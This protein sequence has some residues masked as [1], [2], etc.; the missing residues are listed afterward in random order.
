MKKTLLTVILATS[1]LMLM[2]SV[3]QVCAQ[4]TA[5]AVAPAAA[6]AAKKIAVVDTQR[7]MKESLAAQDAKRQLEA[8]TD[9]YRKDVAKQ[10]EEL[11][12]KEKELGT[13]K[14]VLSADAFE[15]KRKEFK[16]QYIAAQHKVQD[17][18]EKLDKSLA[19]AN[20]KIQNAVKDI[21]NN[22]AKQQGIDLVMPLNNTFYTNPSFDITDDVKKQLDAKLPKV[23][24]VVSD[25]S[26]KKSGDAKKT[27][28]QDSKKGN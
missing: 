20:N 12:K 13:Q 14:N 26:D 2:S 28:K 10:E 24:I 19:D 25:S 1:S 18:R 3:S 22:L 15:Q 16:D 5:A 27:S 7:I 6:P 21:I 9:K 4:T 17:D 23:T 11:G 8:L